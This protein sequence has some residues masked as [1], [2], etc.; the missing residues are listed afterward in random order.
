MVD[1]MGL[2][3]LLGRSIVAAIKTYSQQEKYESC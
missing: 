3:C 2:L 1:E